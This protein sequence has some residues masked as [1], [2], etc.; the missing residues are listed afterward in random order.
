[1]IRFTG[2]LAGALLGMTTLANA[3]SSIDQAISDAVA[4]IVNPIVSTIFYSV[5]LFGVSF[6]LIVGWLVIAAVVFTVYWAPLKMRV[7][8]VLSR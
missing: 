1:M 6:P 3:Q 2:W 7:K 4:P 5:P 8:R